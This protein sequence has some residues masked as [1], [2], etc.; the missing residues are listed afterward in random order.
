MKIAFC[1]HSYH[2]TTGSSA[3]FRDLLRERAELVDFWYDGWRTGEPFD[4]A[5]LTSSELD[6]VVVWQ[7]EPVAR[8]LAAAR[9][10]NVTFFPMYDGCH[11]MP[12]SFW[13]A[14]DGVKIVSFSSTLH[15]RLQRLGARARFARYAPD[16]SRLGRAST[17][18]ELA[19][20]FWQRQQDVTWETIRPLLGDAP[21]RP[22]TIHRAIDPSAGAFVAPS[23]EDVERYAIRT[24]AWFPSRA[25]A[26]ADLVRH[27]VYF[28][29]RLREGIGLSFLEALAMGF[30]VVA[31]DRPTMSEYIV[32]GVNGLLYDP[33]RPRPLDFS[34][35]AELGARARW[36]A[37]HAW[38]KWTRCAPALLDF[39]CAPTA[40]VQPTAPLDAFDPLAIPAAP[41]AARAAP[42]A[43]PAGSAASSAAAPAPAA[44]V[45][46]VAVPGATTSAAADAVAQPGAEPLV[47]VAVVVSRR[48]DDAAALAATLES[49]E[50]QDL[51]RREAIQIDG[52]PG[53]DRAGALTAAAAAAR[54][55]WVL[56]LDAGDTLASTEALSRALEGAPPD[57]DAILGHHL[58][59]H[60]RGDEALRVAADLGDACARLR[61][62]RVDLRWLQGI[63][64]RQATLL[65]TEWLRANRSGPA[66]GGA[67]HDDLLHRL[68]AGGARVHH[69]VAVLA[70][71][72]PDA[73]SRRRRERRLAERLRVALAHTDHPAAVAAGFEAIR[74]ELRRLELPRLSAAALLLE[75]GRT[76]GA[77]KELRGRLKRFLRGGRRV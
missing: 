14:L 74:A 10:R 39:V 16:P 61:E 75:V 50:R 63:P 7:A 67:A 25:E 58:E 38:R 24:T 54:G 72:K 71:C 6:A 13:R 48:G 18:P 65:R 37:L 64:A 4:A 44:T 9:L 33:A 46:I 36:E 31:P 43:L 22:F 70:V 51:A 76:R 2:R 15:E 49:V 35:R 5:P 77:W 28:A 23:P 40:D 17:A 11:A 21:F 69:S 45:P 3:F 19:G 59:R 52:A 55:R 41:R 73:P 30:L 68:A 56:L 60:A 27:N 53:A 1:G 47:T 29:P 42:G 57:A 26:V 34:R 32:S 66:L 12:D 20:Y 62:G 8:Q